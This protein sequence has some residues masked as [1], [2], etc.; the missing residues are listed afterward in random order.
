[1]C[2]LAQPSPE[3]S[4]ELGECDTADL[5]TVSDLASDATEAADYWQIG[6]LAESSPQRSSSI[7]SKRKG[8]G[9]IDEWT[10]GTPSV[11][12]SLPALEGMR[13]P[14][15]TESRPAQA[16]IARMIGSWRTFG[17][18]RC[19]EERVKDRCTGSP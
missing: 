16:A 18:G 1:M 10:L 13:A 7:Q 11:P 19:V 2:C 8:E 17:A 6:N 9:D 3:D 15:P 4:V 12:D 5:S 14:Q